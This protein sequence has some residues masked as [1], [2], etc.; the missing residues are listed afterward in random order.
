MWHLL[1]HEKH[2]RS[3]NDGILAR[4]LLNGVGDL[5]RPV[6]DVLPQ[7]LEAKVR[8][9]CLSTD[10]VCDVSWAT[11]VQGWWRDIHTSYR[12]NPGGIATRAADFVTARVA[13]DQGLGLQ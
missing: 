1:S 4:P 10:P 2:L 12:Y 6:H 8:S 9:Y 3:G 5:G 13:A 11:E 7:S